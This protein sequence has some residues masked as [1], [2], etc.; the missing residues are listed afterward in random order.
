VVDLE[1]GEVTDWETLLGEGAIRRLVLTVGEV[2][3]AFERSG[4]PAAA[5]RP[6]R[7]APE[8]TFIELYAALVS[9]PAIGRSLLG[10]SRLCH[11]AAAPRARPARHPD[12]RRRRL[13]LQGLGLCARRHLRPHRGPSGHRDHPLSRPA[14]PPHQF[15]PGRRRARLREIGTFIIPDDA[16][17]DPAEPWT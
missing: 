4:D 8:D 3:E 15:D 16:E 2:N 9:Q 5:A 13:F 14:A 10:D 12:R 6:E 17:F 1:A 11:A 7:G